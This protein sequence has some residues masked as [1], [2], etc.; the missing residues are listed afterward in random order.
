MILAARAVTSVDV[1]SRMNLAK[2]VVDSKMKMKG[3]SL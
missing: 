3:E 2:V 1:R